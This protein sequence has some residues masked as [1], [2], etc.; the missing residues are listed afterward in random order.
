MSA[1]IT[2]GPWEVDGFS[3]KQPGATIAMVWPDKRVSSD[4]SI[5]RMNANAKAI[6]AVPAMIEA[7]L[8]SVAYDT[9]LLKYAG[10]LPYLTAGDSAEIDAAYDRWRDATVAA[11]KLAGIE[12]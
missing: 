3:V 11:L 1:A 12:L 7:L 9:L 6:A 8:A 2:P 5:A 4:D 10:P